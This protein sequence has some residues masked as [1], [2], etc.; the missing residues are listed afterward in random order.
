MKIYRP[1]VLPGSQT[2]TVGYIEVRE[3]GRP[4]YQLPRYLK[5][6]HQFLTESLH[7]WSYDLDG[8]PA[9]EESAWSW[10]MDLGQFSDPAAWAYL[11]AMRER[12]ICLPANTDWEVSDAEL[13]EDLRSG[14]Y[15]NFNG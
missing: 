10:L 6:T 7:S 1:I 11:P 15:D 3:E 9:V 13:L 2:K 4:S 8:Y 5:G 12:L 14:A